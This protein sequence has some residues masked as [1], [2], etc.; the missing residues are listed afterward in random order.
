MTF[1]ISYKNYVNFFKNN[2]LIIILTNSTNTKSNLIKLYKHTKVHSSKL[3]V[4][5]NKIES[6]NLLK[7]KKQWTTPIIIIIFG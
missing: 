5:L 3:H 7:P 2:L 6:L 1:Y 4:C